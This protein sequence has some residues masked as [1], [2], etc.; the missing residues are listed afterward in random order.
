MN[1]EVFVDLYNIY[2]RQGTAAV[3]ETYAPQFKLSA[4]NATSGVEQ[5][6]NPVAGGS[7]QDLIW[8]KAIDSVGT[9]T[10]V[11]IGKNPNYRN[12]LVAMGRRT[13]GSECV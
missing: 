13:R 5:N 3:D 7:Y 8:V 12:T 6:A 11:P 1:L 9:E 10:S 4:P 2:N